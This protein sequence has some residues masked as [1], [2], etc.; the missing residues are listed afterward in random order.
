MKKR[1]DS[2]LLIHYDRSISVA[3]PVWGEALLD[4]ADDSDHLLSRDATPC[5]YLPIYDAGDVHIFEYAVEENDSG[6]FVKYARAHEYMRGAPQIYKEPLNISNNESYL[7]VDFPSEKVYYF[8][9]PAETQGEP[10]VLP[11]L[12]EWT[13]PQLKLEELPIVSF[14]DHWAA[15]ELRP[16][17]L[18]P[19]ERSVALEL[20]WNHLSRV[21]APR[22][23][24]SAVHILTIELVLQLNTADGSGIEIEILDSVRLPFRPPASGDPKLK[25]LPQ[26]LRSTT[27][28]LGHKNRDSK[29]SDGEKSDGEKS[30]WREE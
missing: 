12:I 25:L 9:N 8:A 15:A 1:G 30:D 4:M 5:L 11:N 7:W 20:P 26:T 18:K 2:C 28:R 23:F 21:C 27:L 29:E 24:R 16:R 22:V 17:R 10:R 19:A 3:S 6:V 14:D 13:A